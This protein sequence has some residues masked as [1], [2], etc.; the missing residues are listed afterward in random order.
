MQIF[1]SNSDLKIFGKIIK[2]FEM[3]EETAIVK[4]FMEIRSKAREKG[5]AKGSAKECK[6]DE[7]HYQIWKLYTI[8]TGMQS[9]SRKYKISFY[10]K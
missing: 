3:E 9:R 1:E 6:R 10:G 7:D 8:G 4:V 2:V 5:S